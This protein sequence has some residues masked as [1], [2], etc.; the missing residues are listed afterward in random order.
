M[1]ADVTLPP[2]STVPD[3]PAPATAATASRYVCP[4]H[5]QII[6]SAPGVCPICGMALEPRVAAADG[7]PNTELISMMRRF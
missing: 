3:V 1:T 7:E 2:P 5:A 6:R 4:M